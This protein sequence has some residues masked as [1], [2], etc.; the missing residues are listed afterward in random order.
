MRPILYYGSK[1]YSSVSVKF[2]RDLMPN[3]VTSLVDNL[4]NFADLYFVA[5]AIFWIPNAVLVWLA[6]PKIMPLW[7]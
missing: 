3:N 4:R 7:A 5:W 2:V 1:I 6:H